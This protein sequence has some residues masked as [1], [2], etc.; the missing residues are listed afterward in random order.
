[1]VKTTSGRQVIALNWSWDDRLPLD[2]A[3]GGVSGRSAHACAF[4]LRLHVMQGDP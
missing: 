3:A 1:M 4:A 2:A